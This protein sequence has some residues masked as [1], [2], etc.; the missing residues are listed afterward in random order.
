M[1]RIWITRS[2]PFA[3]VSAA[4]LCA[5]GYEAFAAP[6]L[7]ITARPNP[8]LPG[9]DDHLIFT[10]RHGVL[11]LAAQTFRRHWPVICVGDATAKAARDMGFSKVQSSSGVARDVIN[12]VRGHWSLSSHIT[13]ISGAHQ[14]GDIIEALEFFGYKSVQ[15]H[16]YYDSLAA[17][18][19]PRLQNGLAANKD[20]YVLLYS[21]RG[22][23][24][25]A[26]LDIYTAQMTTLSLSPAIDRA[27]G[28]IACRRRFIAKKPNESS[29]FAHL[30]P[31]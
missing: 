31:L 17:K 10:S 9:G 15:R 16:V 26:A 23:A 2:E 20:D 29:L 30:P 24:V 13:H 21:P 7:T 3:S 12:W 28:D 25:F 5:K 19:D 27:L 4:Q 8:P 18:I 1:A 11:A 6:L 14:R 22:A